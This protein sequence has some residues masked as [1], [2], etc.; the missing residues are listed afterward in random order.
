MLIFPRA[1]KSVSAE[2]R[3]VEIELEAFLWW[4]CITVTDD[5]SKLDFKFFIA[6]KFGMSDYLED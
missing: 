4:H 5:Q 2:V 3:K 6:D 1:I